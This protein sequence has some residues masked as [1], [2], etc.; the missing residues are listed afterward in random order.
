[1]E[2]VQERLERNYNLDLIATSPSV[3]FRVTLTDGTV[4]TIDNPAKLPARDKIALME[5]PYV[6]ATVI[7]PPEYVGAIME[8]TQ[9]R[10]GTLRTWNTCRR[11]RDPHL[12][13]AADRSDHRLLRPAQVRTK[14]Y[15]S[16]DYELIGYREGDL[17][18]L[19]IL[20]NGEP[21]DA[22]SFIVARDKAPRAAAR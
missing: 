19:E 15:A 12:R 11:P 2:I 3:V 21:V 17:V 4:E 18:K 8:L 9:N 7:T 10:R 5:E 6:K 14:G 20:L 1:M 22:L 16:L 13:D